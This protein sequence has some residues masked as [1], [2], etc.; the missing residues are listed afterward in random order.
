MF[1]KRDLMFLLC[2]RKSSWMTCKQH[3]TTQKRFSNPCK[4]FWSHFLCKC[5]VACRF[6]LGR[7][8]PTWPLW[9]LEFDSAF[10]SHRVKSEPLCF[11]SKH[12]NTSFRNSRTLR[13]LTQSF[14]LNLWWTFYSQFWIPF[15]TEAPKW[16]VWPQ[17]EIFIEKRPLATIMKET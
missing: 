13:H 4:N 6:L 16:T 5:C 12:L 10:H 1:R 8:M 15:T 17:W 7:S 14:L 2:I 11:T 9:C 3:K